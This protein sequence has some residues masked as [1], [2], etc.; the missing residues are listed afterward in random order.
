MTTTDGDEATFR[1]Q[2]EQICKATLEQGFMMRAY[3]PGS[4]A[5]VI[6]LFWSDQQ[7]QLP[8]WDAAL[9]QMAALS[10]PAELADGWGA[11]VQAGRDLSALIA[12]GLAQVQGGADPTAVF[13]QI[14]PGVIGYVRQAQAAAMGLQLMECFKLYYGGR[15]S[16][17]YT[18]PDEP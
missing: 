18:T 5:D 13:T 1:A 12:E 6:Q 15:L 7:R 8:Y 10:P 17:T 9:D 4:S 14:V 2:A 16:P 3:S 11:Y